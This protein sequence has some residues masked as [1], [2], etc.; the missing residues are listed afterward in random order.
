MSDHVLLALALA[1]VLGGLR[2]GG[3]WLA[4]ARLPGWLTQGLGF[5]PPAMFAAMFA[6]AIT[7]SL[8]VGGAVWQLPVIGLAGLLTW[9]TRRP[10]V[11]MLLGLVV[12]W[13]GDL[14]LMQ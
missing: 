6:A 9:R 10:W 14:L 11:G 13:V 7:G 2:C 12:V 5:A 3:F 4:T 1:A 8:A